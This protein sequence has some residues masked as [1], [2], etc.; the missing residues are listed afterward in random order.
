MTKPNLEARKT[1]SRFPVPRMGQETQTLMRGLGLG[2][3]RRTF[4][5]FPDE[6]LA[7]GVW[8]MR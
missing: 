6:L 3:V 1:L 2:R 4:E 5:P 7:I 8:R